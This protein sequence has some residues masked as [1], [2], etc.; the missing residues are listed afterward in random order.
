MKETNKYNINIKGN[1]YF[2]SLERISIEKETIECNLKV[3]ESIKNYKGLALGAEG[4]IKKGII[5]S[6]KRLII[7]NKQLIY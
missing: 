6:R 3:C 7:L 5:L 4:A 2:A 1:T